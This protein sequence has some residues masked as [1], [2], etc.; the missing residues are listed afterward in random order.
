MTYKFANIRLNQG[1]SLFSYQI[2]NAFN[3]NSTHF[4]SVGFFKTIEI[5]TIQY[6]ISP[7]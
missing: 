4:L 3:L 1:F 5:L 2:S 6:L 7:F